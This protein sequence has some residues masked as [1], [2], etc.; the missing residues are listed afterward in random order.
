MEGEIERRE[1]ALPIT[2]GDVRTLVADA[3]EAERK[4]V[5]ARLVEQEHRGIKIISNWFDAIRQENPN[6]RRSAWLALLWHFLVPRPSTFV[7]VSGGVITLLVTIF[8]VAMAYRANI[9]LERQNYRIDVQNILSDAQRRYASFAA[10]TAA[11]IPLLETERAKFLASGATTPSPYTETRGQI[12]LPDILNLRIETLS[13]SLR[14]YR[15]V[16]T[17]DRIITSDDVEYKYIN[18]HYLEF[19]IDFLRLNNSDR[20]IH[21][22]SD[23]LFSPERG[24]LL[25]LLT[26]VGAYIPTQSSFNFSGALIQGASIRNNSFDG[27]NLR[28]AKF[29]DATLKYIDFGLRQD[30]IEF[31]DTLI[32]SSKI[33]TIFLS[34]ATFNNVKIF[35]NSIYQDAGSPNNYRCKANFVT[36]EKGGDM[37]KIAAALT[38]CSFNEIRTDG[39]VSNLE[40]LKV[41]SDSRAVLCS[42]KTSSANFTILIRPHGSTCDEDFSVVPR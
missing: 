15:I 21:V 29:Q 16:D 20:K 40:F 7:I 36:V 13:R 4:L 5:E 31:T 10:E 24:N 41:H 22:L 3:M 25:V 11:L 30:N 23:R 8:G 18:G 27:I 2:A 38:R 35:G 17:S 6:I 33:N 28:G 1:P 42:E 9:L 12:V 26:S 37:Y 32:D 14:P 39:S 19:F 34:N